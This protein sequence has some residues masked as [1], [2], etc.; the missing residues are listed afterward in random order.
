[1]IFDDLT[2]LD[3]IKGVSW[4]FEVSEL[5]KTVVYEQDVVPLK[6]EARVTIAIGHHNWKAVDDRV[7]PLFYLFLQRLLR[8][9]QVFELLSTGCCV[10]RCLLLQS[11]TRYAFAIDLSNRIKLLLVNSS[12]HL[13]CLLIWLMP[14]I[15]LIFDHFR[16]SSSWQILL[17]DY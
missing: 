12:V 14:S 10:I 7:S 8:W 11:L 5:D 17:K 4:D 9:H 16:V 3:H 6:L 15:E 2:C 13:S 1:M